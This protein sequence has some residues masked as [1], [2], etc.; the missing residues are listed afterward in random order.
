VISYNEDSN[1][2]LLTLF[3][4][5]FAKPCT[6]HYTSF[7]QLRQAPSQQLDTSHD[8]SGK[9]RCFSRLSNGLNPPCRCQYTNRERACV[10]YPPRPPCSFLCPRSF[11]DTMKTQTLVKIAQPHPR[12]TSPTGG[13]LSQPIC[14]SQSLRPLKENGTP[15]PAIV[16][17]CKG[18]PCT[19][20]LAL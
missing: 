7:C 18:R 15:F 16:S 20:L 8:T 3:L 5:V 1:I 11:E 9:H 19:S 2:R 6:L 14:Q 4:K 13:F 12:C 17:T 10:I